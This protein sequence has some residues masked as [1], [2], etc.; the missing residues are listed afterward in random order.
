MSFPIHPQID[1]FLHPQ[2][3]S[4]FCLILQLLIGLILLNTTTANEV[5]CE[6]IKQREWE[7]T[8]DNFIKTC[9]MDDETII[10]GDNFT[11]SSPISTKVSGL[12]LEHNQNVKFLP[13]KVAETFPNILGISAFDCKI[14]QISK[15][16]FENL[17]KLTEIHL[18]GNMI[19]TIYSNTFE[20]LVS[21]EVIFLGRCIEVPE[22]WS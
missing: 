12:L 20:D 2:I 7:W 19:E 10:D 3:R 14:K 9:F 21:L 17:H 11:I 5:P 22:F 15:A 16:N 18:H 6:A 4:A 8:I 1:L 13:V